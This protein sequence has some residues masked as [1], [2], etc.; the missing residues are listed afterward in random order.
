MIRGYPQP[1]GN[2]GCCEKNSMRPYLIL[3][4]LHYQHDS[5]N[6][7]WSQQKQNL[8]RWPARKSQYW[9]CQWS[10]KN[11]HHVH[12]SRKHD[13][14]LHSSFV[15]CSRARNQTIGVW[16]GPLLQSWVVTIQFTIH[17]KNYLN[18]Q[19]L[20]TIHFFTFFHQLTNVN[21]QESLPPGG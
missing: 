5:S 20:V 14:R 6:S 8:S 10:S 19:S 3:D 16:D 4:Q 7:Q 15:A 12:V 17:N 1:L 21:H 9:T 18:I 13:K 11:L 2:L